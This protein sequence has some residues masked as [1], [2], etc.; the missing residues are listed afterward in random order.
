MTLQAMLPSQLDIMK[1]DYNL[2]AFIMVTNDAM[3][4]KVAFRNNSSSHMLRHPPCIQ[5]S[6]SQPSMPSVPPKA[7]SLPSS[8]TAPVDPP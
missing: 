7:A 6:T 8:S 2:G 1:D 3:D 5:S 4:L